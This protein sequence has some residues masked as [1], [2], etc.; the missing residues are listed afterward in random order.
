MRWTPLSRQFWVT[1]I[2]LV[3][4][5]HRSRVF[6]RLTT[7]LGAPVVARSRQIARYFRMP[8]STEDQA[9]EFGQLRHQPRIAAITMCNAGVQADGESKSGKRKGPIRMLGFPRRKKAMFFRSRQGDP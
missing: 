6:S 1:G 9:F 3:E 5:P 4:E 7:H 8:Q 2:L